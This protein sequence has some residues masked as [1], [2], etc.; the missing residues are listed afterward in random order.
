M[1][2]Q[3]TTELSAK[4]YA[5]PKCGSIDLEAIDDGIFDKKPSWQC[6]ACETTLRP[7]RHA[8]FYALI[9]AAAI[10]GIITGVG[11]LVAK[12]GRGANSMGIGLIIASLAAAGW[13]F[14][15]LAL[16]RRVLHSS[17][18]SSTSEYDGRYRDPG[19]TS[20]NDNSSL[21]HHRDQCSAD[22][23]WARISDDDLSVLYIDSRMI[24]ILSWIWAIGLIFMSGIFV[25]GLCVSERTLT[26]LLSMYAFYTVP[27]LAAFITG[28]RR[29]P[30]TAWIQ[31]VLLYIMCL[32]FPIG[33]A[34][35][36]YGLS[37]MGRSG[38]QL[39]AANH[40]SHREIKA[41]WRKRMTV[42]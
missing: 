9:V 23:D 10:G 8:I 26:G 3:N 27:L 37:A 19:R 4:S 16:P 40:P 2:L 22:K 15:N 30:N 11:I 35:G 42:A 39:F 13:A 31:Q 5:C 24:S 7:D 14:N 36:I 20:E 28:I 21:T 29:V 1:S 38:S 34:I 12:Q 18:D 32:I 33:T 17:A 25:L 41:E 6:N